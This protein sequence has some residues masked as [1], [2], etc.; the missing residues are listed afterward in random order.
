MPRAEA[1]RLAKSF[2]ERKPRPQMVPLDDD[3]P[4]AVAPDDVGEA[5]DRATTSHA[6]S[7]ALRVAINELPLDEQTILR[8]HFVAG[9][10]VAQISRSMHIDQQRLY[11]ILR[12]ICR[13]FRGRLLAANV[14]AARMNAL[15]DAPDAD[16]DFGFDQIP[17]ARPSSD[18]E[19]D[20]ANAKVNS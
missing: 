6:A 3:A 8:L 14:D 16:L 11:A 17:G 9:W 10:S 2:P 4:F 13:N 12:R 5:R 18:G 1:E 15:L 7:A 19:R 20:G